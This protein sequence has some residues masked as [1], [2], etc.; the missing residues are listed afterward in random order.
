MDVAGDVSIFRPGLL[1]L[2]LVVVVVLELLRLRELSSSAS[3]DGDVE[4]V[5]FAEMADLLLSW[6]E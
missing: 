2:L 5:T 1:L 6:T 4:D 3:E